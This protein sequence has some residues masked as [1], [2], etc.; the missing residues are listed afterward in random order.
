MKK[1]NPRQVYNI[2]YL[3][4]SY[5]EN[6]STNPFNNLITEPE[7][8]FV[9]ESLDEIQNQH[10]NVPVQFLWN[11]TVSG[12]KSCQISPSPENITYN[13]DWMKSKLYYD[14]VDTTVTLPLMKPMF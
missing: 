11:K 9:A 13:Y 6:K 12:M 8:K 1:E 14:A 4:N 10:P 2:T 5:I 3:L 7:V